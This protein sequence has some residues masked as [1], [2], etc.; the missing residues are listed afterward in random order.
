[1]LPLYSSVHFTRRCIAQVA[2][3]GTLHPTLSLAHPPFMQLCVLWCGAGPA[4][5]AVRT[6]AQ[7]TPVP[8]MYI[9]GGDSVQWLYLGL[10]GADGQMAQLNPKADS[11]P[12]TSLLK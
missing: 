10:I 6:L 12:S 3:Y 2:F 11:L 8:S 7:C 4:C 5:A 9:I 1:M